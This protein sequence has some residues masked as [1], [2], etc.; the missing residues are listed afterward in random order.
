[1]FEDHRRFRCK[2]RIRFYFSDA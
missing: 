1:M 2:S